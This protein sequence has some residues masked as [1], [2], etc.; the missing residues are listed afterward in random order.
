MRQPRV[1]AND[2]A[3]L[4][5]RPWHK[6]GSVLGAFLWCP[7]GLPRLSMS[8]SVVLVCV[9]P[10]LV[11]MTQDNITKSQFC[12]YIWLP[13]FP[14]SPIPKPSFTQC[15]F[16]TWQPLPSCVARTGHCGGRA[17]DRSLW[18]CHLP[19]WV[20]VPSSV[21]PVTSETLGSSDFLRSRFTSLPWSIGVERICGIS[22]QGIEKSTFMLRA[23][24]S[25]LSVWNLCFNLKLP[26][27]SSSMTQFP[28]VFQTS[29]LTTAK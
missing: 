25:I 2:G 10:A 13:Y 11:G 6:S 27:P 12:Y 17:L 5:I 9:A 24:A 20:S 26:Q 8:P 3:V 22:L 28:S 14:P 15:V 1:T 23:A 4:F 18:K 29:I 16:P 19:L 21:T 7:L